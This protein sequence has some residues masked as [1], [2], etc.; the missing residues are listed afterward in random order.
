VKAS[1]GQIQHRG[2]Y[3]DICLSKKIGG[4]IAGKSLRR[5][6]KKRMRVYAPLERA[7]SGWRWKERDVGGDR[8]GHLFWAILVV[9]S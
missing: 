2:G 3:S 8:E 9:S 7:L 4:N 5:P 1:L 6:G